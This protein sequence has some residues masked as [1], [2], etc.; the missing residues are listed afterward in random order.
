ML[1]Q[2]LHR[3]RTVPRINDITTT[4]EAPPSFKVL[5]SRPYPAKNAPLQR[6]AY[7]RVEPLQLHLSPPD[8]FALVLSVASTREDWHLANVDQQ[9]L[10]FEAV[11]TTRL[12]RFKDDI[13]VEIRSGTLPSESAVHVRSRSRLGKSDLGTN[14]ERIEAFLSAVRTQ[15]TT[16]H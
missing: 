16:A 7:P 4:P 10:R 2:W 1:Q 11:A 14:A 15:S 12:L 3:W 8:A 9:N 13:V 6:A 5:D